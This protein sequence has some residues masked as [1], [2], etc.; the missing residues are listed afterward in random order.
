[1]AKS[2]LPSDLMASTGSP[3]RSKVKKNAKQ[4]KTRTT[5]KRTPKK[6]AKPSK[7]TAARRKPTPERNRMERMT[8]ILREDQLRWLRREAFEAKDQGKLGGDMSA[9][10]RGL[11]DDVMGS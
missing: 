7:T 3:K 6:K 5:S 10:V 1:M 2:R 4:S 8:L 11:I 9:I